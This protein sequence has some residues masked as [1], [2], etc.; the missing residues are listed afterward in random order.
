MPKPEQIDM[1]EVR[2]VSK[3]MG[4]YHLSGHFIIEVVN[5]I[6]RRRAELADLRARVKDAENAQT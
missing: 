1:T 6:L 4:G 3:Q 2:F 5:E